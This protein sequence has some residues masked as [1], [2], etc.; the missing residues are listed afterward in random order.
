M[1]NIGKKRVLKIK[2]KYDRFFSERE[3]PLHWQK[4]MLRMVCSFDR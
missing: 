2:E 1:L 4:G 3:L